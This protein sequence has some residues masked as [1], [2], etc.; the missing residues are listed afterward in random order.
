MFDKVS[1]PDKVQILD[2][3]PSSSWCIYVGCK[4]HSIF[5]QITDYFRNYKDLFYSKL[6]SSSY[7]PLNTIERKKHGIDILPEKL[8]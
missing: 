5:P 2:Q 8:R 1:T 3:S 6:P 4:S 7:R